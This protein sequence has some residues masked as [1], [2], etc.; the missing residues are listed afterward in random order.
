MHQA[1]GF[2]QKLETLTNL[3]QS[4]LYLKLINFQLSSP[5]LAVR[6]LHNEA[7]WSPSY[8]ASSFLLILLL[9]EAG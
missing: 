1:C 3:Q 4:F 5:P 9:Q 7:A 2:V 6:F 8:S